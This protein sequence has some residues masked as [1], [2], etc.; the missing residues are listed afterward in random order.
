L[1][2]IEHNICGNLYGILPREVKTVLVQLIMPAFA[3]ENFKT[4]ITFQGVT[5]INH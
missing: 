2:F 1:Y 3:I 5:S 4:H